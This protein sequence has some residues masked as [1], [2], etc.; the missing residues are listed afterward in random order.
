MDARSK[1]RTYIAVLIAGCGLLLI[2]QF[3]L[4]D[5]MNWQE[6]AWD[7]LVVIPLQ[8][9]WIMFGAQYVTKKIIGE[10]V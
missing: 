10:D 8:F 6:T 2:G 3:F 7:V 9:L 1:I 5:Y 4:A